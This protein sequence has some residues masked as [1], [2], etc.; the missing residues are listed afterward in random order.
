MAVFRNS[1]KHIVASRGY[2]ERFINFSKTKL[3]KVYN[4]L[5]KNRKYP[6]SYHKHGNYDA[7][8]SKSQN[9]QQQYEDLFCIKN[10]KQIWHNEKVKC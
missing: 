3:N 2:L 7:S 8:I 5:K 9:D 6:S 10:I 4:T 1:W